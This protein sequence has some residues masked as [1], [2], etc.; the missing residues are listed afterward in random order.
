MRFTSAKPM[1]AWNAALTSLSSSQSLANSAHLLSRPGLT[2]AQQ[3]L[4]KAAAAEIGL[5][6]DALE[7]AHR[8]GGRTLDVVAPELRL[9]KA[10]G[11][12][13]LLAE[14]EGRVRAGEELGKLRKMLR[15]LP[16]KELGGQ[17]GERGQIARFGAADDRH[18]ENTSN[19][20]KRG[21]GRAAG[22]Q[23][24]QRDQKSW[25]GS[26]RRS[27]G[28]KA[29]SKRSKATGSM[30]ENSGQKWWRPRRPARRCGPS[31][32]AISSG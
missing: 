1:R 20:A 26:R 21:A 16:G 3:R 7:I 22:A 5:D 2:R 27:L 12:A 19:V 25:P 30:S 28:G 4:R 9:R 29:L 32:R 10:R 31:S 17:R 6:I 13:A 11:R 8:T 14:E 23:V 18:E 15:L 24:V